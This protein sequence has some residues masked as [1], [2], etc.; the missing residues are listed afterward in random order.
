M[1]LLKSVPNKIGILADYHK[2][3]SI[4]IVSGKLYVKIKSYVEEKYRADEK[5]FSNIENQIKELNLKL[6]TMIQEDYELFD[7]INLSDIK[8]SDLAEN[9][10][11]LPEDELVILEEK[12]ALY[13]ERN[14]IRV[15]L[16]NELNILYQ[17]RGLELP[18]Q[19]F[20]YESEEILDYAEFESINHEI[21]Y[22]KLKETER[23]SGATDII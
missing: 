7:F 8:I 4:N 23:F 20:A 14:E 10:E 16:S 9:Q 12:K 2:I 19:C 15:T 13:N 11:T 1:A 22:N 17:Q 5:L 3:D 21:I 6:R 18:P